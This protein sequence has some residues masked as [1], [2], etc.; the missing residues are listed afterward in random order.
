MSMALRALI[1][2][3]L[4]I[5]AYTYV[6]SSAGEANDAMTHGQEGGKEGTRMMSSKLRAGGDFW[7]NDFFDDRFD[8]D[9][10]KGEYISGDDATQFSVYAHD[11]DV[12]ND[13]GNLVQDGF[14]VDD[15]KM[16]D[17]NLLSATE[18]ITLVEATGT[19][20]ETTDFFEEFE[21]DD[22]SLDD[23]G[24]NRITAQEMTVLFGNYNEY[25]PNDPPEEISVED[26]LEGRIVGGSI[27]DN[28]DRYP[29][30]ASILNSRQTS[31]G[32]KVWHACG[33]SLIAPD[34]VLSAAHC[35]SSS[36]QYVQMGKYHILASRNKKDTVQTMKIET[37]V[38]HPGW[39]RKTFTH[40][41]VLLKLDTKSERT[42]NLIKLQVNPD[43]MDDG[44]SVH[45][46]GW[47]KTRVGGRLSSLMKHVSVNY[48]TNNMCRS[49]R[50]G[51]GSVIKDMMMCANNGSADACQGDSGG[52]MVRRDKNDPE[53][54]MKDTQAGVVSWGFGCS[55][56]R[57]PGVYARLDHEWIEETV[58]NPLTGLSPD[59]C[60]A[61]HKL[62]TEPV[63]P[64]NP[65]S[66]ATTT[67]YPT[68]L[69]DLN[70]SYEQQ[71]DQINTPLGC[72][73]STIPLTSSNIPGLTC[74]R[75]AKFAWILCYYHR[76]ECPQSC[77]PESCAP[78][79][80]QCEA[81]VT[82]ERNQY[83][84]RRSEPSDGFT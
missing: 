40:D 57:Y 55:Y 10:M 51:Y 78:V 43:N 70:M 27:V 65:P 50:Y 29:Y 17:N 2:V 52:P 13:N 32:V 66:L 12:V 75:V 54:P 72:V 4:L 1:S 79:T 28:E 33:G 15:D 84:A 80:G 63:E 56:D 3:F 49:N 62:G 61:D 71:Y 14:D 58:C 46:M 11:D 26:A 41:L 39:N 47:G 82:S 31:Y 38:L 22:D 77:C 76:N 16:S 18:S 60:T 37:R 74:S 68:S 64:T 69:S 19:A 81:E 44:E 45:V 24:Q 42:D 8:D 6:R 5:A 35:A 73:D 9:F 67:Y 34:V 21:M 7:N 59:S 53:N 20:V 25:D 30:L 23:D 83:R 48:M 36:A